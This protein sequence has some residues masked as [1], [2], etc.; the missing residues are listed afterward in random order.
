MQR[1]GPNLRLPRVG[2]GGSISVGI[3]IVKAVLVGLTSQIVEAGAPIRAL[4]LPVREHVVQSQSAMPRISQTIEREFVLV[5]E[6]DERA[7]A[8]AEQAGRLLCRQLTI[9]RFD[10]HGFTVLHRGHDLAEH[11]VRLHRQRNLLTIWADQDGRSGVVLEELRQIQQSAEILGRVDD[12]GVLGPSEWLRGHGQIIAQN[13]QNVHIAQCRGVGDFCRMAD[14]P[15]RASGAGVSAGPAP[16]PQRY[17]VTVTVIV[18]LL[19]VPAAL[20]KSTR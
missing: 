17:L 9:D 1:R 18:L 16:A 8:H 11:V 10:A 15:Q 7:P 20:V 19:V 12:N 4:A 3:D 14:Q 5:E 6:A 2:Q 13:V